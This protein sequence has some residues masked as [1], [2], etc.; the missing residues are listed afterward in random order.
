[1]ICLPA[2]A[3]L[4]R[5]AGGGGGGTTVAYWR[6]AILSIANAPIS[7]SSSSFAEMAY[8]STPGGSNIAT[9]GTATASTQF[10]GAYPASNAFDGNPA[11]IWNSSVGFAAGWVR[12]Q[13]PSPVS[14]A[15]VTLTAR[16]DT[17]YGVS[18]T[19][20]SFRIE[21][22]PDGVTWTTEWTVASTGAWAD[23]ETKTFTRP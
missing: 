14:I 13:F 7:T 4:V 20:N 5:P 18:Q 8:R 3:G 2:G 19:P 11:T 22:S 16:T 10:S 17:N 12:Y 6:I 15:E 21:S 1:M 23:G 9:G